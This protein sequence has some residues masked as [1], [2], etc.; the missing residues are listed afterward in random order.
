M[1]FLAA[2]LLQL[3]WLGAL[4]GGVVLIVRGVSSETL[5]ANG[6]RVDWLGAACGACVLAAL[7]LP[8][9]GVSV[10]PGRRGSR[11]W[12]RDLSAAMRE[13]TLTS[14]PVEMKR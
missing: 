5:A 10:L 3:A 11:T 12:S 1:K 13:H 14:R 8:L 6:G 7:L 4:A 2:G 9:L